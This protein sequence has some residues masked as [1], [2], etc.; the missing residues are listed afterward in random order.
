MMNKFLV[1]P[2][3]KQDNDNG[4]NGSVV[5]LSC[6]INMD[7]VLFFPISDDNADLINHILNTKPD[8]YTTHQNIIGIYKTMLDSWEE[9]GRYL[10]GIFLDTEIDPSNKEETIAVKL[11]ISSEDGSVD[12][13]IGVNFT[14]AILLAAME[15]REIIVSNK[16]L[17]KLLPKEEDDDD[18]DDDDDGSPK[19]KT[20][21][22]DDKKKF[23]IDKDILDLAK[24]IMSGKI[25]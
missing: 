25:K 9:G 22:T 17:R 6:S 24:K 15:R 5:T 13:I 1:L 10:S 23:P 19:D 21:K 20:D 14:H 2:C 11:I 3:V 18:E 4:Y 7:F 8:E 16:L 12:S